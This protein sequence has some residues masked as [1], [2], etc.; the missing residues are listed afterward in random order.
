[1]IRRFKS[2]PH[3]IYL[4][5]S[6]FEKKQKKDVSVLVKC[7]VILNITST[8][9]DILHLLGQIETSS[10]DILNQKKKCNFKKPTANFFLLVSNYMCKMLTQ[11]LKVVFRTL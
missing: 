10:F 4:Y 3:R 5:S 1:M 8:A 2:F 7:F 11:K 6:R 9:K